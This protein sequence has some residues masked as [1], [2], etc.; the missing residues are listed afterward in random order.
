MLATIMGHNEETKKSL[1]E[2][3]VVLLGISTDLDSELT[4]TIMVASYNPNNQ[5]ASILSIPRDTFIGKSKTKA[6]G[7]EKINAVYSLKG[8]PEAT[9]EEVNNIT[10][11]DT[12]NYVVVKTEALIK[13]VD[14]LGGVEFNVPID[15]KYDDKTQNL[16]INLKAGEQVL[17]GDQAEQLLRFRHNND[18]T[19]Y[20]TE[21]GDND[22]GRMRTQR[23][24]ISAVMRQTLKAENILKI[25]EF[26]DIAKENV[27]TNMDFDSIKDYIPYMV[28]FSTE[29]L[30]TDSLPGTPEMCNELWFYVYNKTQTE[31]MIQRLFY[32]KTTEEIEASKTNSTNTTNTSKKNSTNSNN[33]T[34]ST[35][36]LESSTAS[37]KNTAIIEV[38]NG[39]GATEKFDQAVTKLKEAGF[40]IKKT[41]K[42]NTTSHTVIYNKKYAPDSILE[43]IK[44]TLGSGT[45][46][47][48]AAS[49]SQVDISITIGTDY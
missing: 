23:E 42:T 37:S 18:G 22:I 44:R 9:L 7:A 39:T 47:N 49:T 17:N 6:T 13:L 15:M 2:L 41:S 34:A 19:S 40:N 26:L 28:E 16:H 33:T 43:E 12:E 11:L 48:S 46:S 25:G 29:N 27:T 20:P 14:V 1:P 8:G 45:I 38:L 21:Y 3:R 32:H 5:E 35:N 30:T 24:F 31:E 36:S 4:D 10:G